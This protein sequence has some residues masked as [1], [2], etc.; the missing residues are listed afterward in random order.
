M[1][2]L[3]LLLMLGCAPEEVSTMPSG[4]F[5]RVIG[6]AQDGGLPHAACSC[7][8]CERARVDPKFR[9]L[10]SS[11]AIV[12]P[13][14][15]RVYLIDA[16]P[17]I[18][19]QLDLLRDVRDAPGDRVDRAPVDGVFLTH[20]HLGHYTGLAFFGFEAVHTQALPLYVTEKMGAF[21]QAHA[22]WQQ[23]IELNNVTLVTVDEGA[24]VDLG[25]GVSVE[26]LYVPHRDEYADTVGYRIRGP[27]R[28]VLFIPD[29]EPWER[30]P[31]PLESLLEEVDVALLDATF[32]SMSELPG[33][34]VSQ[35]GHPLVVDTLERLADWPGELRFIHL[36]HSNPALDPDSKQAREIRERGASVAADGDEVPL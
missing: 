30:W 33:R 1:R 14:S 15:K 21:L 5:V 7:V 26:P 4:P 34:D 25:E 20:A 27:Q 17:D 3:I 11:L 35:I 19:E 36:N 22:P 2:W 13:E 12:L 10:V 24:P 9:R 16:T 29:T 32:Y 28:T 8:R 23:L 18:R 6:T 31:R